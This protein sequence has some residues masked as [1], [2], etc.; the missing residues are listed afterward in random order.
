MFNIYFP[1]SGFVQALK[2]PKGSP[3]TTAKS[4]AYADNQKYPDTTIY[5][6]HYALTGSFTPLAPPVQIFHPIFEHFLCRLADPQLIPTPNEVR[7]MHKLTVKVSKIVS[8]ET[9]RVKELRRLLTELLGKSVH[10]EANNDGTSADGVLTLVLRNTRTR[11]QLVIL[12]LKHEWDEGGCDVVNQAGLS[13]WQHWIQ[14]K[15]CVHYCRGYCMSIFIL[16]SRLP[17]FAIGVVAPLSFF[18]VAAPGSAS[19][20]GYSPISSSYKGSLTWYPL[21]TR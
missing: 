15:V 20:V 10:L 19:S 2:R 16:N 17:T 14:N 5:D 3:L 12:E 18:L 6:G 4:S 11:I 9:S 1:F 7:N 21:D 13:M 8:A